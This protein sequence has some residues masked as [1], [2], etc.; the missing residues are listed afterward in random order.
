MSN[1]YFECP[2]CSELFESSRSFSM[3]LAKSEDEKHVKLVALRRQNPCAANKVKLLYDKYKDYIESSSEAKLEAQNES[4]AI[5]NNSK[6]C[7]ISCEECHNEWKNYFDKCNDLKKSKFLKISDNVEEK[8]LTE[9]QKIKE[10]N[11]NVK[12]KEHDPDTVPG[13]LGY[14]YSLVNT[15]SPNYMKEIGQLK[16]QIIHYN[17]NPDQIRIIFRYLARKGYSDIRFFSSCKNEALLED[18][19]INESKQNGTAAYLVKYFYNK[20][21]MDLNLQTL[22]NDVNKIKETLNGGLNYDQVKYVLDYM[23]SK[24]CYVLNFIGNNKVQ[25]LTEMSN[26]NKANNNPS[27]YSSN[28]LEKIKSE[29]KAAKIKLRNIDENIKQEAYNVA[30]QLY[31]NNDIK[32]P[33]Y[34]W[35]WRIGLDLDYEMYSLITEI[36]KLSFEKLNEKLSIDDVTRNKII[37]KRKEFDQWINEYHQKFSTIQDKLC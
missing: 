5:N 31:I 11:K 2:I 20:I 23:I 18:Q 19:Y 10:Q 28:N 12:K 32:Y 33:R 16:T 27:F 36:D 34:E 8:V 4:E 24:K 35:A 17:L 6:N 1:D 29:L 25:A 22:I 7:K 30:R 14:F 26:Y 3:H 15:K 13:L 37:Q 9:V 21:G